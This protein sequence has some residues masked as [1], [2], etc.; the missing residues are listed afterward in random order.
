M[1]QQS[2]TIPARGSAD[3]P[4][5]LVVPTSRLLDAIGRARRLNDWSQFSYRIKGSANWGNSNFSVPFTREGSLDVI[6]KAIE[7]FSPVIN[8]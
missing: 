1:T 4:L 3:L 2:I 8:Q 7:V 5:Q 6:R